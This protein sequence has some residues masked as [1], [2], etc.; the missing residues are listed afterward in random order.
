[1]QKSYLKNAAILTATGL[2][3]RMAGMFFRVYIAG[4]IGAEGMGVYQLI[5]TVYSLAITLATAGLSI[6]TTRI[7][8]GFLASHAQSEVQSAMRRLLFLGLCTGFCAGSGLFFA[9]KPAAL[10]WLHDARAI[11]PLQILAPSLPFMAA[12]A[13]LR[14]YFMARREVAPNARAQI[15]EQILRIVLVAALLS[16]LGSDDIAV[17]CVAVVCGNTVSEAFSWFY[18]HLCYHRDLRTLPPAK[19]ARPLATLLCTL[20]TPIVASQYVT[21][22]LHTIENVL[23]PSCLALFLASRDTALAQYGALKAMAMPVL[24]FPFSF[25]GTLTTLLLPEITA[26]YIQK[27]MPRLH[28]LIHRVLLVSLTMSGLAAMLFTIFSNEIG[29]LLY[30]SPEIG[31]YLR[32]L[33]PLTPLM[34]L[35]SMV[36]GILKG[37]D[38]QISTFRYTVVDSILR[39]IL[40][41]LLLPRFGMKGFLLIMVLSNLFTSLLNLQHLLQVVHLQF[42]WKNWLFKPLFAAFCGGITCRFV[43]APFFQN[44]L[45]MAVWTLL[46]AL[47]CSGVYLLCLILTDCISLPQWRK[48]ADRL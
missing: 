32:V 6:V 30:H 47:V 9:A 15:F 31:F 28:R 36:D 46:A 23:V 41:A 25:L 7:V 44:R 34:Y 4:Q 2:V 18:M 29:M 19:P 38:E 11:L 48:N 40:I 27:N 20:L 21:G 35:E 14:G 39:I 24:F 26:A 5:F 45:S 37:L 16:R 42:A 22:V 12:S 10:Y 43:L 1:M 33:G 3:L 13:I 8:A 17:A